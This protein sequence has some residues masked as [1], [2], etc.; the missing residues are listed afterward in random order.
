MP[1]ISITLPG[2]IRSKKNSKQP[3]PIPCAKSTLFKRFPRAGMKPVRI[4]LQ[5]SKAYQE[6]EKAARASFRAEFGKVE[7]IPKDILI[8]VKAVAYI[9]GVAPDLSGMCESVGDCLEGF[10]WM[11]DKQIV[12]WDGSRVYRDKENPRTEIEVYFAEVTS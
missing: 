5:P 3:L 11:D 10:A 9:K 4:V 6:W 2:S 8:H 7:P 1:H 12:S